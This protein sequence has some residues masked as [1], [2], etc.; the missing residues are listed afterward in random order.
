MTEQEFTENLIQ[1][2]IEYADISFENYYTRTIINVKTNEFL[3]KTDFKDDEELRAYKN[4]AIDKIIQSKISDI[5]FKL[6]DQ[7]INEKKNLEQAKR[8][9]ARL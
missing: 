7:I 3:K 5:L 8:N 4:K 2:I 9:L 1:K 6:D